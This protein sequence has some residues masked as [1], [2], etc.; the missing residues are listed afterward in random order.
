[1]EQLLA[2]QQPQPRLAAARAIGKLGDRAGLPMLK[3]ALTD[4]DPA[5]R[6]TAA[7]SILQILSRNAREN[8]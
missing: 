6:I 8:H 7:G 3:K 2:D 1:L 5:I 4:N